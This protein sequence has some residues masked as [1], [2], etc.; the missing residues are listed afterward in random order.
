MIRV[1]QH[2][3]ELKEVARTALAC[4]AVA[5]AVGLSGCATGQAA[6]PSVE[7]AMVRTKVSGVTSNVS[8]FAYDYPIGISALGDFTS[9]ASCTLDT[10]ICGRDPKNG[11]VL[12]IAPVS[13]TEL[14]GYA[15]IRSLDVSSEYAPNNKNAPTRY[16][17]TG[18]RGISLQE[19]FSFSFAARGI[20]HNYWIQNT[21]VFD[22]ANNTYYL[23][24]GFFTLRGAD[25]TIVSRQFY[26][27]KSMHYDLPDDLYL[28]SRTY[29]SKRGP[30]VSLQYKMGNGK[31]V[32]YANITF[33]YKPSDRPSFIAGIPAKGQVDRADL[34]FAGSGS[35]M[36]ALVSS[37]NAQLGFYYY[38]GSRFVPFSA[39]ESY[40]PDI[41]GQSRWVQK[42][43]SVV[44]KGTK[45]VHENGGVSTAEEVSGAKVS[46]EN[47]GY[48]Q[49]TTGNN[50]NGAVYF[51]FRPPV[52][53]G[54]LELLRK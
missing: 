13:T 26:S 49:V 31:L 37:I 38:D 20:T 4:G 1:K 3:A 17:K 48:A 6:H 21:A 27:T 5:L 52:P 50:G 22:T 25:R 39:F 32:T 34:V 7:I 12:K 14:V 23:E 36:V 33:D 9:N 11:K 40:A 2:A 47:D 35:G 30:K 44:K 10:M 46:V 15:G 43:S 16:T 28:I 29:E 51:G 19:N 42:Y 45:I 41:Y 8:K 18:A 24:T 53:E 54:V